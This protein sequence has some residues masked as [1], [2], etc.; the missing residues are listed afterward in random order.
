VPAVVAGLMLVE[1]ALVAAV[2]APVQQ[3]RALGSVAGAVPAD[4]SL[5]CSPR[6]RSWPRR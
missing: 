2:G 3:L 5:R 6:W 4:P 1:R